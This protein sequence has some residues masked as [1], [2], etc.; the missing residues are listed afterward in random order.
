MRRRRAAAVGALLVAAGLAA[1][2]GAAPGP[3]REPSRQAFVPGGRF[4]MG[5]DARERGLARTLSSPATV[6]ADWFRGELSR[7]R[8]ETGPFCIDRT[9]VSQQG[10]AAFVA[11]T[12]HRA[13]G[14]SREDYQRQGYLVHDYDAVTRYLWSAGAPPPDL[15][16]HPV[17]L[18][19]LSDAEAY[20]A[21]RAP[22]GRLPTEA[23][24]EKAARGAEGRVFP[25][26][27]AW[28]PDR[29]NS[30]AR[31]LHATTPVGRYPGGASPYGLLDAVGNVFQWTASSFS[32]TAQ[33]VKGC[34]WDDEAGLCRPAF[35]HG[36]APASRHVLIGF[37]CL[38]PAAGP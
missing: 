12:G 19:S 3:C 25:W 38:G 2:V 34:A 18:V 7:R 5:S 24:W 13:P 8:E 28:D 36:R 20:C 22:A 33:T 26:G 31:G 16:H 11:R 32:S 27:D 30:A 17:V 9:L 37:R 15:L 14:I 29:L 10:Y 23:E 1:P 6:A 21:W 4:V 35:R